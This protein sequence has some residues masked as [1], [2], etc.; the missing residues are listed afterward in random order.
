MNGDSFAVGAEILWG[1]Q[2]EKELRVVKRG[3]SRCSWEPAGNEASA[4]VEEYPVLEAITRERLV[5]TQQSE[6]I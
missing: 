5:K 3:I 2:L 1:E 6:K 4:E